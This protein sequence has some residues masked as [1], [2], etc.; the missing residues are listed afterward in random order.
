LEG[1]DA[2]VDF[3]SGVAELFDK[4]FLEGFRAGLRAGGHHFRGNAAN[5]V[6][7]LNVEFIFAIGEA[8]L[9]DGLKAARPGEPLRNGHEDI[10]AARIGREQVLMDD[11]PMNAE[12][13]ETG[14]RCRRGRA[15]RTWK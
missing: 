10:L 8:G 13:G 7:A 5:F 4:Y 6:I 2:G 15:G 3:G 1:G 14:I 11:N 9:R 12:A